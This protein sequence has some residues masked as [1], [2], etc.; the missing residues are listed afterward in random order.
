MLAMERAR[1]AAYPCGLMAAHFPSACLA[2]G[3]LGLTLAAACGTGPEPKGHVHRFSSTVTVTDD[4][5]LPHATVVIPAFSTVV[6]RNRATKE[7]AIELE[8]AACPSCDTV[9][10]FTAG[11]NGARSATIAPGAIATLCFHAPGTFPFVARTNGKE[12]RG[13]IEVGSAP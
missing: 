4:A 12:L 1:S 9:Y 11:S 8:A 6:W 10:G 2:L 7:M 13:A 3:I 5:L